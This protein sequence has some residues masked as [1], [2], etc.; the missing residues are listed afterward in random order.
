MTFRFISVM[1]QKAIVRYLHLR[2]MS[3]DALYEDL[4]R[5]LSEN[6]VADSTVRKYVHSQKFSRR[7][8]DL[9]HSR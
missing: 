5:V 4:V 1:D 2:G 3:L 6:A 7:M 9:L 8:M